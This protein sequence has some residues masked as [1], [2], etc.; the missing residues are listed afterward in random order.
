VA[1]LLFHALT[2][3]SSNFVGRSMGMSLGLAPFR[4]LSASVADRRNI[5]MRLGP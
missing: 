2:A 1:L 5:S 4:I 3:D